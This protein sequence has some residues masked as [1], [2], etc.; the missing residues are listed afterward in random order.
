MVFNLMEFLVTSFI[1]HL[2]EEL[3]TVWIANN[4]EYIAISSLGSIISK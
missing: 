1:W 2:E 3:C 4:I